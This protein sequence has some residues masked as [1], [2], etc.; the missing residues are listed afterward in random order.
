[1]PPTS[2]LPLNIERPKISLQNSTDIRRLNGLLSAFKICLR[3][4]N[5]KYITLEAVSL[6]KKVHHHDRQGLEK[7]EAWIKAVRFVIVA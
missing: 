3:C 7:F 4:F 1:M 2:T 5:H 6:T